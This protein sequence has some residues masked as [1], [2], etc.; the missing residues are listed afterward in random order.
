M[1]DDDGVDIVL[2][3]GAGTVVVIAATAGE[4]VFSRTLTSAN[5]RRT[6]E[7]IA[8]E[9]AIGVA[10]AELYKRL[11]AANDPSAALAMMATEPSVRELTDEVVASLAFY[12]EQPSARRV[13]RLVLT[14]GGSLLP[15]LTSA[16]S[17]Q[18]HVE[19]VVADPFA[20]VRLGDTGFE[21]CDLPY[22][23]YMAAAIG[24]ALGATRPKDRRIDLTPLAKRTTSAP[25]PKRLLFGVGAIVLVGA[26]GA[27]FMSGRGAIA[28]EQ[29]Q[30][31]P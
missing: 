11:G 17:D 28:D 24:I 6:T 10:E 4:A 31:E 9:L 1:S 30:L 16:L 19:V 2:S 27:M 15:G 21:P 12:G 14:G 13:R 5:G 23:C 20:H 26:A 3:I 25:N 29:D 8:S 18:L 22:L 7:R